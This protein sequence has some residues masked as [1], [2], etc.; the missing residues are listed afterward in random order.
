M[1]VSDEW[2]DA[3]DLAEARRIAED[4]L[5][6]Y[7]VERRLRAIDYAAAWQRKWDEAKALE[8]ASAVRRRQRFA[9][10]G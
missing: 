6:R 3:H 2:L 8:A 4:R 1:N 7:D 5:A 9:R 10:V